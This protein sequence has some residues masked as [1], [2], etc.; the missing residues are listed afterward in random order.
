MAPSNGTENTA[1]R[2]DTDVVALLTRQHREIE[3]RLDEVLAHTGSE[4]R[5]A[6][7][8]LVHLLAVHETAE[9][10]VVHPYARR[11]V[12]GG[13]PVVS[14]RLK[15]EAAAKEVLSRLEGLDPDDPAFVERFTELRRSVLEHARA[16]EKQ[17]FSRL[18]QNGDPHRLE[19][20]AKAVRAAEAVAPTRPHPGTE[21]AAK[22]LVLGPATAVADRARDAVRSALRSG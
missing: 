15:E 21:S 5:H 9:E 20:L 16:E 8:R 4:R 12:A 3:A 19:L 7:E 14:D 22:N 13:E 18:R 17:E 11:S 1:N 6:F 10:E 2:D